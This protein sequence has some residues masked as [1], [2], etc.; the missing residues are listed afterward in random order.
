[1]I[2]KTVIL[3]VLIAAALAGCGDPTATEGAP[4]PNSVIPEGLKDCKF[5]KLQT[6][7]GNTYHVV[8]CPNSS[9]SLSRP[10]KGAEYTAT[11]DGDKPA[12]QAA[13]DEH[14]ARVDAILKKIDEEIARLEAKKKD[15]K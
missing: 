7:V 2:M 9:T 6:S 14:A 10:G 11:I 1:M 5:Y 13:A 12:G 4:V 8:R 3:A 15:L